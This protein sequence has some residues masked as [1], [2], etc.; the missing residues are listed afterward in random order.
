MERSIFGRAAAKDAFDDLAG[1]V[2]LR[3]ASLPRLPFVQPQLDF[4]AR[5]C[6]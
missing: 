2:A 6:G 3:R 5:T 4:A 1:G